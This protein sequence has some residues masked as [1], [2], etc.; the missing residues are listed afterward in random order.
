MKLMKEK[1]PEWP[2]ENL[3]NNCGNATLN[4]NA[5]LFLSI[6]W[7]KSKWPDGASV[8]EE[9]GE[10]LVGQEGGGKLVNCTESSL[11]V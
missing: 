1:K 4:S 8:G 11:G 6:S 7:A 9:A 10:A 2:Y 5:I 3:F